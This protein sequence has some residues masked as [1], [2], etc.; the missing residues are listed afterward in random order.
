MQHAT[1]P[2]RRL[3]L[4]RSLY[5]VCV[6]LLNLGATACQTTATA[7]DDPIRIKFFRV[8]DGSEISTSPIAVSS[9]MS[10]KCNATVEPVSSLASIHQRIWLDYSMAVDNAYTPNPTGQKFLIENI[11]YEFNY[12]VLKGVVSQVRVQVEAQ[13]FN[14]TKHEAHL[15]FVVTSSGEASRFRFFDL[16]ESTDAAPGTSVTIR[17]YYQPSTV[18]HTVNSMQIFR[19]DG[20]DAEKLVEALTGVDFFYYQTGFLREYTFTVPNLPAGATIKHRFAME[21]SDGLHYEL[22]HVTHVK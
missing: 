17:P 10:F 16:I 15:T 12:G 20:A 6:L 4:S 14:G 19:T 7:S 3:W 9:S 2:T 8:D 21:A 13:E 11:P 18:T 1:R 22:S 5:L